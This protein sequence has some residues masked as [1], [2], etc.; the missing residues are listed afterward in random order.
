MRSCTGAKSSIRPQG[1]H[2]YGQGCPLDPR[3]LNRMGPNFNDAPPPPRT[4]PMH[5]GHTLNEA[6]VC[7]CIG[8]RILVRP[9]CSYTQGA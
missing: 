8:A 9:Q 2:T 6:L 4:G 1:N 5:K 3:A 7:S